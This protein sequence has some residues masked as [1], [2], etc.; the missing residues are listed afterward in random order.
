MAPKITIPTSA[1]ELEEMLNDPKVFSNVM[2]DPKTRKEFLRNYGIA[3]MAKDGSLQAQISEQ[4]QMGIAE[5]I[6]ANGD[7]REQ[8]GARLSASGRPQV[9]VNGTK[10]ISRGRGA[11]YNQYAP[12]ADLERKY[13][14][15]DRF[16]TVGEICQ[17]IKEEARPSAS[18][19]RADL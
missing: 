9:T 8:V 4:V 19:N 13:K 6:K 2:L 14:P 7:P 11:V 12:G 15:E 16:S 5:F 3:A 18:R 17:A 10:A 1:V